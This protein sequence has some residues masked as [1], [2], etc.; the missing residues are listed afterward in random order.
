MSGDES[1]PVRLRAH[2]PEPQSFWL[3]GSPRISGPPSRVWLDLRSGDL[4]GDVAVAGKLPREEPRTLYLP[5]LEPDA[6][7]AV[8]ALAR[9]AEEN[10]IL[11]LEQVI[12]GGAPRLE[13]GAGVERIYDLSEAL[14]LDVALI[15][16]LPPSSAAVWPLI[17]GLTDGQEL[18]EQG[19]ERLAGAGVHTVVPRPVELSPASRRRL[20]EM[21]GEA[22]FG[23]LFHGAPPD[24]R[25]LSRSL[26]RAGMEFLPK[27]LLPA[28]ADPFPL[29]LAAELSLVAEVLPRVGESPARAQEFYVAARWVERTHHDL[30]AMVRDGN[31]GIV[32]VLDDEMQEVAT[33]L[34]HGAERSTLLGRLV[35][36]YADG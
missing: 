17:G 13:S 16:T 10:E 36:R 4:G 33:E 22:S 3:D 15:D 23:K 29:N 21:V 12:A 32:P 26:F 30:E 1:S 34:L 7:E 27:R 8:D 9:W 11:L 6:E 5:P 25:L 2:D 31:I 28:H 14:L 24:E 18:L 19:V 35:A 20:T